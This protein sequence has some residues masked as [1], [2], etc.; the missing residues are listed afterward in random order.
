MT[1]QEK[2]YRKLHRAE[3]RIGCSA[4]LLVYIS[5]WLITAAGIMRDEQH[6][7]LE[8]ADHGCGYYRKD[9]AFSIGWSAIPIIPWVLAPFLTGFYEHGFGFS[10]LP[11]CEQVERDKRKAGKS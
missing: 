11:E 1:L 3:H 2:T 5:L 4:L 8:F 7:S 6:S 9:L 10:R